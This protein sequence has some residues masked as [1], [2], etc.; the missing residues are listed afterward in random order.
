MKINL[1]KLGFIGKTSEQAQDILIKNNIY[2]WRIVEHGE[3]LPEIEGRDP[4]RLN[5]FLNEQGKVFRVT[6]K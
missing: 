5:L 4:E 1:E 6:R 2:T 3:S